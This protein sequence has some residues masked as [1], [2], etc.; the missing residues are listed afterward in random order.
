LTNRWHK[1]QYGEAFLQIAMPT[2]LPPPERD[3]DGS[4]L[5]ASL[6]AR[7]QRGTHSL[8]PVDPRTAQYTSA[9]TGVNELLSKRRNVG[10]SLQELERLEKI[11]RDLQALAR[12]F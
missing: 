1:C 7:V 12:G 3:P 6:R 2:L 10:G 5:M 9:V 11:A 4:D 8:T